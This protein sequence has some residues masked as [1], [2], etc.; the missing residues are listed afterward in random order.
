MKLSE[1]AAEKIISDMGM[2]D[3]PLVE[4]QPI[5]SPVAPDWFVRY[6]EL[7][8]KFLLSLTD[9]VDT[10]AFMNFSESELRPNLYRKTYRYVFAHHWYGVAN[11]KQTIYF[12]VGHFH[13]LITWTDLLPGNLGTHQSGCPIP[14]KRFICRPTRPMV[15]TA[16][17]QPKTAWPKWR[18]NW[19][20]AVTC[21]N[22]TIK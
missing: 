2:G 16:A 7:C 12:Y 6:K 17:M 20:R 11:W 18:R 8:Q 22:G 15:V 3:L 1:T 5:P 21:N 14:P 10:L 13:T 9:S 4:M 19:Q